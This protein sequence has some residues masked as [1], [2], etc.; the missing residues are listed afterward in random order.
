MEKQINVKELDKTQRAEWIEKISKDPML[1]K[2]IENPTPAMC[3]EAVKQKSSTIDLIEDKNLKSVLNSPLFKEKELD[4]K[5]FEDMYLGLEWSSVQKIQIKGGVEKI[6]KTLTSVSKHGEVKTNFIEKLE[7]FDLKKDPIG[8][9]IKSSVLLE[10]VEKGKMIALNDLSGNVG[11]Y[12]KDKELNRLI[13]VPRKSINI[14]KKIG[15]YELSTID[16]NDLLLGKSLTDIPFKHDNVN[17]VVSISYDPKSNEVTP[18]FVQS[19][20]KNQEIRTNT[21]VDT[22]KKISSKTEKPFA[23]KDEKSFKEMIGYL[24]NGEI[25]KFN[26]KAVKYDVPK[27]FVTQNIINNKNLK[28]DQKVS[29]MLN[30]AKMPFKEIT[31]SLK[32]QNKKRLD[33][34]KAKKEAKKQELITKQ[35][36]QQNFK[37]GKNKVKG[38]AKTLLTQK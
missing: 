10:Q 19:Q 12:K 13:S 22:M 16:V 23:K 15:D 18:I 4:S 29:A 30:G 11:F 25:E 3:Y 37:E 14:P 36:K 28:E 21:A 38:A 7:K 35:H 31:N 27:S 33:L 34:D 17:S 8:K 20:E 1:I 26:K 32:Y 24:D 5:Q 6:G 2:Q 9:H